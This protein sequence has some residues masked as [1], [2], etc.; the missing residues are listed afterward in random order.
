VVQGEIILRNLA[1]IL[2]KFGKD[3][4]SQAWRCG[5]TGQAI[6]VGTTIVLKPPILA[7]DSWAAPSFS[8]HSRKRWLNFDWVNSEGNYTV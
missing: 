8:F 6:L 1:E 3:I 2:P 4:G 5:S 7:T